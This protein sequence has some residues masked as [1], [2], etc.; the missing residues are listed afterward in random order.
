MLAVN[1]SFSVFIATL[2]AG[3]W[4]SR[5][6]GVSWEPVR[7]GLTVEAR[8]YTLTADPSD[9]QRLYVG[10]A[11]GLW[12]SS[13]AGASFEHLASDLNAFE[14]WRIVID[15]NDPLTL[16]AG[17]RP[18]GLYRSRDAG[19]HWEHLSASFPDSCPAVRVPRVTGLAVDP[20]NSQSIWAGIEVD[21]V[22]H[23]ADGGRSWSRVPMPGGELD[24]H[25]IVITPAG[26]VM[27]STPGDVFVLEPGVREWRGLGVKPHF[28]YHYCRGIA[29]KADDPEVLLVGT[30]DTAMGGTGAIQR[31]G[32]GGRT[33]TRPVLP[34]VPNSP[35]WAFAT[36]RANPEL[37]FCCSH[38]GQ[39]V[40][41]TDGGVNWLKSPR[42]FTQTRAIAILPNPE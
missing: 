21:G 2:G 33:W 1:R 41:S 19:L 9:D 23:S 8:I 36:S 18:A 42:E 10:L 27:V 5:D 38:Y 7:Q 39:L 6:T 37:L 32:D 40:H 12:R 26:R 22:Q 34:M 3:L 20:T 30:G 16:Y 14:V 35:M 15:P 28:R 24:I 11:S 17:T 13:D 29:L 31:T 4:R 25:D